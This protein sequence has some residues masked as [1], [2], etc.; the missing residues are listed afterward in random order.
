M[1][2]TLS[3]ESNLGQDNCI[4]RN[5]DRFNFRLSFLNVPRLPPLITPAL[6]L[7]PLPLSI[8]NLNHVPK[9]WILFIGQI[10]ESKCMRNLLISL[11][12]SR[13]RALHYSRSLCFVAPCKQDAKNDKDDIEEN[14]ETEVGCKAFLVAGG[15]ARL[16]DLCGVLS[17]EPGENG[18]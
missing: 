11:L 8:A 10:L 7:P 14:V 13:R 12:I 3:T 18:R 9:L 16:E 17:F 4:P 1:H 2:Y 5:K 6:L 15:I